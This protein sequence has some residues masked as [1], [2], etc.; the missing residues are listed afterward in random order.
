[1]APPSVGESRK[2]QDLELIER[3]R[4]LF[5]K[6]NCIDCHL[7]P[8]YTT[9][10]TYDVGI[11]DEKGA[12]SFNPPSLKGLSQRGPQYFHDNRAEGIRGV[13]VDHKHKL[14]QPLSD[15]DRQ[16]LIAFLESL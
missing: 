5:A 1:M 12:K 16:A 14:E 9:P 3:G 8:T 10:E 15:E 6:Q 11:R 4:V 2:T 7:P 13:L